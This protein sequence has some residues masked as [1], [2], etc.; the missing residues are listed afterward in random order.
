MLQFDDLLVELDCHVDSRGTLTVLEIEKRIPFVPKRYFT[1]SKVPRNAIRGEHGHRTCEQFLIVASG[2]LDVTLYRAGVSVEYRLD[3]SFMGL[4]IPAMTWGVQQNPSS[5]M[6]LNVFASESYDPEEYI[7]DFDEFERITWV[8]ESAR[9]SL[10][11]PSS[12]V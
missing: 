8:T 1:V 3:S 10:E 9:T 5:D 11:Q 2:S 4:H 6:V 7:R 12:R